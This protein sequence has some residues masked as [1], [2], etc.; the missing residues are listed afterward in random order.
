MSGFPGLANP[1][2][3]HG[4]MAGG[5]NPVFAGRTPPE[6]SE[7]FLENQRRIGRGG[8]FHPVGGR[9]GDGRFRRRRG[10]RFRP[11]EKGSRPEEDGC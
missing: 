4:A 6:G 9:G 7:G 2:L 1:H 10:F 8:E 5:A 11:E 3:H